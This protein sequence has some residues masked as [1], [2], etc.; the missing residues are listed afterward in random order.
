ML[1]KAPY[2]PCRLQHK[3]RKCTASTIIYTSFYININLDL[4]FF[5]VPLFLS[6]IV[7]L[8][9]NHILRWLDIEPC[10]TLALLL[11]LML[12]LVRPPTT[13]YCLPAYLLG[14][15]RPDC[16]WPRIASYRHHIITINKQ[17]ESSK[18]R[19]DAAKAEQTGHGIRRG[20]ANWVPPGRCHRHGKAGKVC[21]GCKVST[22]FPMLTD[23]L[24]FVSLEAGL[25]V[26]VLS[27]LAGMAFIRWLPFRHK[28]HPLPDHEQYRPRLQN[29]WNPP[30]QSR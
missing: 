8:K 24:M 25:I 29:R 11:L 3:H 7:G 17:T 12:F 6:V 30:R 19:R 23:W 5:L 9:T 10:N 28:N 16:R 27:L 26:I 4:I 20:A 2:H 15:S 22:S 13:S 14:D 18:L 21:R 1:S